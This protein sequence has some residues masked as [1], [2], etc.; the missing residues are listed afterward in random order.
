VAAPV[1]RLWPRVLGAILNFID[2]VVYRVGELKRLARVTQFSRE[3]IASHND[4]P[5]STQDNLLG[6]TEIDSL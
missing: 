5:T 1:S 2:N 3:L 6:E 4:Y